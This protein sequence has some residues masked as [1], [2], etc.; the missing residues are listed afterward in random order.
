MQVSASE[1]QIQE[2]N[3]KKGD[4]F[5]TPTSETAEDIGHAMVIEEDLPNT[6]Y[7]YHLMRLRPFE[8][9]FH[10]SFPNYCLQSE[11]VRKQMRIAA[12]GVQRM[13]M[14]KFDFEDVEILLPTLSEQRALSHFFTNIDEQIRL[15]GEKIEMLKRVKGACLEGM[16]V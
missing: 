6:C 2:C 15:E 16:M 8:N 11:E 13:V 7:S 14:S 9:I 1:R 12:K 3:V 5:F 4:I 10:I